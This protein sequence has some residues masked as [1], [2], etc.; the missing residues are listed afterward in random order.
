MLHLP[1]LACM[2]QAIALWLVRCHLR[3]ACH[4]HHHQ[5]TPG[6]VLHSDV[7][8]MSQVPRFIPQPPP[9]RVNG[10]LR[11][12]GPAYTTPPPLTRTRGC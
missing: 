6:W 12:R 7:R 11:L 3:M 8:A 1:A 10:S 2:L 5:G 4:H 9:F